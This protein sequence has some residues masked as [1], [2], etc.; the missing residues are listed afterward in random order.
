MTIPFHTIATTFTRQAKILLG[1]LAFVAASGIPASTETAMDVNQAVT[2]FINADVT[3]GLP[4]TVG[5]KGPA[6]IGPDVEFP[7]FAFG[8]SDVDAA[9]DSL[10]MTFATDP[11]NL[12]V[13][14]YDGDT[15]D[16]YYYAFDRSVASA[17]ISDAAEGFVAT[18]EIMQAGET[19]ETTGAFV[20]GLATAF[21]SANGEGLVTIGE[22]SALRTVGQGGSLTVDLDFE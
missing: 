4:M 16:L 14:T 3:K 9:P 11:S 21:N 15:R 12:Q 10:T 22:G 6:T 1:G 2:V 5:A 8:V 19:L 18:V 17:T 13:G 20:E 7:G